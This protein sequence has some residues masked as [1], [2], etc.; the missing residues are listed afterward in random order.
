MNR[1][2]KRAKRMKARQHQKELRGTTKVET[3][4]SGETI[5]VP[6]GPTKDS[7]YRRDKPMKHG[8]RLDARGHLLRAMSD[9][10]ITDPNEDT[11]REFSRLVKRLGGDK[12]EAKRVLAR[13]LEKAVKQAAHVL[14]TKVRP[15]VDEWAELTD[16][17]KKRKRGVGKFAEK[18]GY[19][20]IADDGSV[21]PKV[22]E[23]WVKA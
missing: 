12:E 10:G 3:F 7:G 9:V 14:D 16:K 20:L 22:R 8:D 23:S 19:R 5:E 4:A 1:K 18:A 6:R 17:A 15:S 11:I 13:Q 2:Q 21:D